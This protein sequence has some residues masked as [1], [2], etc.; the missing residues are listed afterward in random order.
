MRL[1]VA[2][3]DHLKYGHYVAVLDAFGLLVGVRL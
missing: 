2:S 3:G 1:K